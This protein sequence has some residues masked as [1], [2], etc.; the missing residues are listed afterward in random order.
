MAG[1]AGVAVPIVKHCPGAKISLAKPQ[2]PC[3]ARELLLNSVLLPRTAL[4]LSRAWSE[5]LVN[6]LNVPSS[7][8]VWRGPVPKIQ[9]TPSASPS[10]WHEP[11]LLQAS[12]DCFPLKLRG[13]MLRIGVLKM[14]LSGIPRAVKNASLPTRTACAKLPGA[15]GLL[16]GMSS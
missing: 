2:P 6:L 8:F 3:V 7:G 4:Q 13:M 5:T 16:E 10:G 14:L 11:Q 1:F 9:V 12:L 15:G